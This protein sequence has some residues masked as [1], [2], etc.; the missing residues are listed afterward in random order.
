MNLRNIIQSLFWG[1]IT[2]GMSL[3]FQLIAISLAVSSEQSSEINEAFL[4][5]LLFLIIYSFSEEAFKY[6]IVAKKIIPLSYGRGFI[7][8]TWLAGIG[9]S[10]VESFI[11]Y[12]KNI[13]EKIDFSFIDIFSTAPLHILTFGIFGYFLAISDKKGINIKILTFNIIIHFSYNYSIIHLDYY[14]SIIKTALI[15]I[16]LAI[17]MYGF[18]IINKKLA[19][20][21]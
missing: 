13:Y 20:D 14:S 15:I 5:S 18:L 3:I 21:E 11:I 8:N 7:L 6:F 4:G 10:L 17:N 19:S 2:A 1:V 12:Q 16:L 9:F